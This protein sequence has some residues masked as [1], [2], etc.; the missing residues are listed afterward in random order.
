MVFALSGLSYAQYPD[1]P[2]TKTTPKASSRSQSNME[3]GIKFGYRSSSMSG[4]FGVVED[5]FTGI[6][7]DLD[8]LKKGRP[9]LTAGIF[10]GRKF[11]D[12]VSVRSEIMYSQKG[13]KFVFDTSV[14]T[15]FYDSDIDDYVTISADAD[16]EGQFQFDYVDIIGIFNITP[17]RGSVQPFFSFGSSVSFLVGAKSKYEEKVSASISVGS[18]YDY[19]DTTVSDEYDMKDD[20]MA[21]DFA[22]ILGGG[23]EFPMSQGK[24]IIDVKYSIGLLGVFEEDYLEDA[25]YDEDENFT[26]T[27]LTITAGYSFL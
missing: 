12:F 26:N 8:E 23:L 7:L 3:F 11:S 27:G 4:E 1:Q 16:I 24:F 14:S 20:V 19:A 25:F 9:G 13:V 21:M 5:D 15:T 6:M 10:F 2:T 18:Y 17:S 22:F